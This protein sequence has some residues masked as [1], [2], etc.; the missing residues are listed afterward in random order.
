MT[1]RNAV[2][3]RRIALSRIGAGA[4]TLFALDATRA[5]DVNPNLSCIATPEQTEGPYF[6]DERLNRADIR[7]DPANGRVR[8]GVPLRLSLFVHA[9]AG[10]A[11]TPL[12]DAVVDIWH[13]DANGI[14]SDVQDPGFNS[15]GQKFL[16]GYQTTAS[17][18]SVEFLTIYPGWYR[19]RATHVHFKVRGRGTSNRGYEFTS[20]L[21][22]D[23]ALSDRIY[24]RAPYA[25]SGRR[26]HNDEDF[27]YRAGG[28]ALTL[29]IKP[30]GDGY[31]A[32]FDVGLRIA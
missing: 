22:F 15:S 14:Y 29:V 21:Y 5:A 12:R 4:L 8:E 31:T 20:Q 7:S 13:C 27:I 23:E 28:R 2:M 3:N 25:R 10:G 18:G 30:D 17:D 1:N 11:C 9:V 32:R 26:T 19:G 16:R 6:V 24:T